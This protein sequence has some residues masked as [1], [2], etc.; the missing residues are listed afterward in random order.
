MK[1][2]VPDD[3]AFKEAVETKEFMWIY[4]RQRM[5]RDLPVSRQFLDGIVITG[6]AVCREPHRQNWAG[7]IKRPE[8][9]YLLLL[10]KQSG[11]VAGWVTRVAAT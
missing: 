3:T 4:Q 10:L 11:K 9:P 8:V 7:A 2:S 1:S 5:E 6:C